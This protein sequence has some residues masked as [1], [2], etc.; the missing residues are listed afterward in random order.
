L[1]LAQIYAAL[2]YYHDHQAEIDD[3]I[4]A[5]SQRVE[6]IK[7]ELGESPLAKKQRQ[8]GKTE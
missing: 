7:A 2:T 4:A 1:N 5:R 3:D 6:E 8:L